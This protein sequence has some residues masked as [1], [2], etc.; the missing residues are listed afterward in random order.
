MESRRPEDEELADECCERDRLLSPEDTFDL[1]VAGGREVRTGADCLL[2][3]PLPVATTAPDCGAD[4]L[5]PCEDA[6][7]STGPVRERPCLVPAL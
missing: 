2:L 4:I 3:P 7:D 5:M 1:D 6:L